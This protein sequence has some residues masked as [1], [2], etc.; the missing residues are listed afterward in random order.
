MNTTTPDQLIPLWPTWVGQSVLPQSEPHNAALMDLA[1]SSPHHSNLF[2][3]EHS[4]A[5]WLKDH[6]QNALAQWFE[7]MR[8][9]PVPAFKLHAQMDVLAFGQYRE[10]NNA[11]GAYLSGV[12]FVNEP[13]A[14]SITHLRS[15][16]LPSHF[17]IL[18]PRVG[19][20]ALALM[21]D[22]NINETCTIK[23][24]ESTLMLWPAY[25]RH[26]SRVHLSDTPWVRVL[27]RVDLDLRR[28]QLKP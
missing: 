20:N 27:F 3:L 10:L 26:C 12:Y 13:D 14:T 8:V 5:T 11:P 19:F 4:T 24:V 18:D 7:R 22:P 23:P 9:Q 21:G 16:C 25:L 2:D 6:L 17:S 15:D 28:L 1:T